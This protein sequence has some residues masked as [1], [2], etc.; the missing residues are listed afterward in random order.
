MQAPALEQTQPAALSEVEAR[1]KTPE[2]P[3]IVEIKAAADTVDNNVVDGLDPIPEF[4]VL[5]SAERF[6]SNATLSFDLKSA[7]KSATATV[8]NHLA[9]DTDVQFSH[10]TN[11]S[12]NNNE[13][14]F[15][16]AS[17]SD[18]G[19]PQKSSPKANPLMEAKN[20]FDFDEDDDAEHPRATNPIMSPVLQSLQESKAANDSIDFIIDTVYPPKEEPVAAGVVNPQ[21]APPP[22]NEPTANS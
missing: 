4:G 3:P 15:I 12:S 21:T 20:F 22:A 1:V 6:G 8:D 7:L 2:Q 10:A 13:T 19:P 5:P 18:A 16:V 9:V 14:N 17:A 11:A